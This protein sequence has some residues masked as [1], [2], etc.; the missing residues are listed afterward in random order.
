LV[1]MFE[2]VDGTCRREFVSSE[3]I[4]AGSAMA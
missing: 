1:W 4:A 2:E 3:N